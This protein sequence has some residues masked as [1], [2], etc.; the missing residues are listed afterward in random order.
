MTLEDLASHQSEF[1]DPISY[2]FGPEKHT[3]WECPPNGQGLAALIAFGILDA[4]REEGIVDYAAYEEGSAEWFHVLMCVD[5]EG[6]RVQ[7]ELID[8]EAMR[9]A[10]ADAHAYIADPQ[11][12]KVPV[13]ELLSKVGLSRVKS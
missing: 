8:S 10:F 2:S 13:E 7:S 3:I 4:L 1:V 5:L 11:K 12:E 6:L 9:L